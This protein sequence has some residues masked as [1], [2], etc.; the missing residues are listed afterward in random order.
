MTIRI[1]NNI[2]DNFSKTGHEILLVYFEIIQS[3]KQQ[4][5]L[6]VAETIDIHRFKSTLNEMVASVPLNILN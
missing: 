4:N 2:Y 3:V 5:K 1:K 6:K